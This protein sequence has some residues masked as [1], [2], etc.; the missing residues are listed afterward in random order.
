MTPQIFVPSRLVTCHP[1][2]IDAA[3]VSIPVAYELA[4]LSPSH[5][6]F[7]QAVQTQ[8]LKHRKYHDEAIH[9]KLR[10]IQ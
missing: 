10:A 9:S 5:Q 3:L 1:C 2:N 7:V 4:D 8:V 6:A